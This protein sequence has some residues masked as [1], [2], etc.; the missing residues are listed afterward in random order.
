V[1][2][3]VSVVVDASIRHQE[4]TLGDFLTAMDVAGRST[5][6]RL[7]ARLEA[8]GLVSNPTMRVWPGAI[9]ATLRHRLDAITW[10]M[11]AEESRGQ[12]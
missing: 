8:S 3:E 7:R 9:V 2:S 4:K 12:R 6:R 10:L 11:L 5:F 1:L